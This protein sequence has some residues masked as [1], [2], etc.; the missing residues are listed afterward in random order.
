MKLHTTREE[1]EIVKNA[2]DAA[3]VKWDGS[4]F[5]SF[6][7]DFCCDASM[8]LDDCNTLEEELVAMTKR[9]VIA[10]RRVSELADMQL[11]NFNHIANWRD[12]WK[13]ESLRLYD[14][15]TDSPE[16]KGKA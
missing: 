6:E 12:T 11:E 13:T 9:A 2:I 10:E 16:A 5:Q 8:I 1:R 15:I 3:K 7:R 4:P 14:Q